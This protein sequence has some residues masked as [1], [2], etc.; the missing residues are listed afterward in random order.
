MQAQPSVA[1]DS[2]KQML[3]LKIK[4]LPKRKEWKIETISVEGNQRT[5][6]YI[7][8]R[9]LLFFEGSWIHSEELFDKLSAA[10]LNVLNTQLFLE[11]LPS[12]QQINDSSVTVKII[13]KERWYIWP[14][15][16]IDYLDRNINA[17]WQKIGRAHV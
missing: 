14:I 6:K 7:I 10:R 16:F 15:P 17:W 13:V 3:D 12:F 8:T 1:W 4:T 9:E 2:A 11:V 5:K